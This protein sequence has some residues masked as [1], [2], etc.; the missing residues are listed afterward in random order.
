LFTSLVKDSF[1]P[2]FLGIV[3]FL[4]YSTYHNYR[5]HWHRLFSQLLASWHRQSRL[6]QIMLSVLLVLALG[7]FVQRDIVN[8]VNYHSIEPNCSVVLN[9]KDCSAYSAWLYSYDSHQALLASKSTVAFLNPIYYLGSWLYWMW[10]RLF[11]AVNG[12]A[13]QFT[14][15]P[16][17]PL[18]S[19]TAVLIGLVG[20]ILVF[21]YRQKVFHNNPF[22]ALLIVVCSFY[23]LSLL[24]DGYAQ[25]RY[26]NE[27]V[28]MNGRYLLPVLLLFGAIMGTAF[29]LALRKLATRKIVITV[30]VLLLFLQGG[31]FLTFI[32]RSDATWDWSNSIV[33]QVNNAARKI[34]DPVIVNGKK[35][36]TTKYWVFN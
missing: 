2:I 4:A 27:L 32:S 11:F 6:R 29:S 1:L 22:L 30:V 26:T 28:T 8:L 14:N 19:A 25:Y 35:T 12:P 36:Y 13:S 21:K 10:Y 23:I 31:G 24:V 7:M 20:I 34:T 33:I 17:L 3:L 9:V 15:Y 16:P 5:G 18:P